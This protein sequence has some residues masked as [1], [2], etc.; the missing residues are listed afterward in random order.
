MKAQ[1]GKDGQIRRVILV[2]EATQSFIEIEREIAFARLE[3]AGVQLISIKDLESTLMNVENTPS[4]TSSRLEWE[5][6]IFVHI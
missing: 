4:A 5:R 1:L 3:Q 6:M 2:K